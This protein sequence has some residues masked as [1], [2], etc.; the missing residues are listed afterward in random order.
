MNLHSHQLLWLEKKEA[1]QRQRV[2]YV[3]AIRYNEVE[4]RSPQFL[5]V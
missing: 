4:A 5:G 3:C 1:D 2:P